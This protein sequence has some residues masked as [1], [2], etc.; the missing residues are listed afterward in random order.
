MK[1]MVDPL[2]GNR[3]KKRRGE[4]NLS[5]RELARQTQVTA[6]FLS[7]VERGVCNP[8]LNSLRRIAD[9]LQV[10]LLYFLAERPNPSPV[11]RKN[12]R[13]LIELNGSD[14]TGVTYEML[15]PDLSRNFVVIQGHLK[16]GSDNIF[17]PLSTDTEEMILVL[18]GSLVVGLS[19]Q[20]YTI[21][22]GD[23]ITFTG[24]EL[25]KLMSASE[26]EVSWISVITPPVF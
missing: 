3:L 24:K 13:S 23:A 1:T 11:V 18:N 2:I 16:P 12:E 10:P 5:L 26:E 21:N 25:T 7:Q 20:D 6:A 22:S 4:L 17:R 15:S 14:G 9:S 19:D 8:S